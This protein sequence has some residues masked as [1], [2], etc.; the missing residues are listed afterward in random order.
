MLAQANA[1]TRCVFIADPSTDVGFLQHTLGTTVRSDGDT[2]TKE[3]ASCSIQ[4]VDAVRVSPRALKQL[5]MAL[6][7]ASGVARD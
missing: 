4:V 6:L 5:I 7:D 2:S 3:G 1:L